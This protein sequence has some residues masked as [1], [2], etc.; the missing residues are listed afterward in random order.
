MD[1]KRYPGDT[2]KSVLSRPC[3]LEGVLVLVGRE[4]RG[5]WKQKEAT[6]GYISRRRQEGPGRKRA[7]RGVEAER[8]S[9]RL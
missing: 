8:S 5:E 3:S 9:R 7:A 4:L 6:G 2:S 1:L